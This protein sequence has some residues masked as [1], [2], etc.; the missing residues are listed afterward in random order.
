MG[1]I[2]NGQ[3]R[4]QSSVGGADNSLAAAIAI[5]FQKVGNQTDRDNEAPQLHHSC[6]ADIKL[7]SHGVKRF[8]K[9]SDL[10]EEAQIPQ[11][12]RYRAIYT[13]NA[14]DVSTNN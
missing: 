2:P 14:D 1:E 12:K 9:I 5:S 4:R 7:R 3:G 8:A 13:M 11:R 10:T 6:L